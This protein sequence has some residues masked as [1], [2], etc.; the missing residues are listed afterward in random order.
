[1]LSAHTKSVNVKCHVLSLCNGRIEVSYRN[2][3]NLIILSKRIKVKGRGGLSLS[4]TFDRWL[5]VLDKELKN[6]DRKKYIWDIYI[7]SQFK[8]FLLTVTQLG[9]K[10]LGHLRYLVVQFR[11]K[12]SNSYFKREL[13]ISFEMQ[14]IH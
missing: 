2:V 11:K 14:L 7:N 6:V 4:F 13:K 8:V 3:Q 12:G 10:T 9:K 5:Y 1:M